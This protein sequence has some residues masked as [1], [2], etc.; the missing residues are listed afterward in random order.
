MLPFAHGI[1][2]RADLPI[3]A[4]WFGVAAAVVLVVSFVALAAGWSSPRLERP[5]ER[6][7]F[8][9]GI[10]ADVLLGAVGVAAF[11]LTVYAGLAGVSDQRDN[12]APTAVYVGFWVGVAFASLLFGDVWRLLSPW[13]AAGRAV[14]WALARAGGGG[15]PEP[16]PYPARLG[17]WPAALGILAFGMAELTWAA[18]RDPAPLA[19][20]MLIYVAV[21]ALGM[22]LYGV[23]TWTRRGDAFGVWFSLLARLA[24]LTRRRGVLYARPPGTGAPGLHALPGTA[25]VLIAGI[26]ITA[27]DGARE[28]P[29]F[30]AVAPDVQRVLADAGMSLGA[31][32]EWTFL[33]GML[34]CVALVAA[35]YGAAVA[36]MPTGP[37]APTRASLARR[38]AHGLI[39][40]AAAYLVAHYFSLLA[41][42]GQ[43]LWRLVRAPLDG[44]GTGP[45]IDYS[46]V[47]ATAIWYVQVATLVAGHVA[48]LV[49]SHDRALAVYG[50]TRAAARS[51]LVM[52][53]VMVG[54]T[55]LGL[56]LLSAA[57]A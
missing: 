9:L 47:S 17:H 37:G 55:C 36:G 40:I 15:A 18:A 41:Y 12:L 48:A 20:L 32:L 26:G 25:A 31:A 50:S 33:A 6:R 29:V 3:P 43:D 2:G 52:L 21:Q 45:Q 24:P 38:F 11:A 14:G 56:Y 49:L 19:V 10:W 44:G 30:N 22:G 54:F 5:R 4:E 42:N 35:I 27:F 28:G 23:E 53:G 46:V 39:P 8:R 51:Q 57:N 7:L 16:L 1:A 13:R 34:V